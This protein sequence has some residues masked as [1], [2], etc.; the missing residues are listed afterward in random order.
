M[1]TIWKSY[2]SSI[3]LLLA[4]LI[5]GIVGYYWGPGVSVLQPIADTFLNLLYVSVVPLIFCS[6]T[7]SIARMTDIA[8]LRRILTNFVLG[9]FITGIITSI[10]FIVPL[11]FIDPVGTSQIPMT[12]E[13]GEVSQSMNLLGMFT[14]DD[15]YKLFSR[16]N[17]MALIVFSL[18]FS[19]AIIKL[20]DKGRP[21]VRALELTTEIMIQMIGIFM[22]LAPIGL[23]SYFAILIGTNGA[24]MIGP[25]A[26]TVGIYLA[27]FA[28][29]FIFMQ[30]F[31]GYVS[32]GVSGAKRWW[33][34]G[35][36][37]TLTALASC[38]SAAALPANLKQGRDLG[39]SKDISDL[40][41][42]LGATLHKNGALSAQILKIAFIC[43]VMNIEFATWTNI[44]LTFIVGM[45]CAIVVGGIPGGGYVA[46][47]IIMSVFGFPQTALPMMVMIG[48]LTD[49]PATV[50]NVT[51]DTGLA[52][53]IA[54]VIEGKNWVQDEPVAGEI[55]QQET[56]SEE[57]VPRSV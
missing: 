11:I 10:F 53:I 55:S 23:G 22:K 31:Y 4:M 56:V 8:K 45:I 3:L 46:E 54:R 21:V 33:K 43:S 42:P 29:Y 49:A 25:M 48:T 24:E 20:G 41:I 13:V 26:R 28:V 12:Q 36:T 34:T 9:L 15:F 5:G 14:V 51:G 47:I 27:I 6:L 19:F 7:S 2:G 39:I 37:P 40:V 57:M 32:Y 17:L 50:M 35:V 18:L 1:K 44:G 38:S 52:M 30:T 16:T